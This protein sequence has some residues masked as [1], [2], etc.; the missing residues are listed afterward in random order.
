MK[1]LLLPVIQM[2]REIWGRCMNQDMVYQEILR[3]HTYGFM[4]HIG[5]DIHEQQRACNLWLRSFHQ[6]IKLCF[7]KK[8]REYI[9][10]DV[11]GADADDF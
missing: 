1:K 8:A 10:E 3:M 7:E 5:K 11:L 2:R 4:L 6:I 9:M